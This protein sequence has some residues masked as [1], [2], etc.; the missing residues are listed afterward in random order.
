MRLILSE[1][2]RIPFLRSTAGIRWCLRILSAGATLLG[3]YF[4]LRRRWVSRQSSGCLCCL[5]IMAAVVMTLELL[6]DLYDG[7]CLAEC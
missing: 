4:G 1:H 2:G 7:T 3:S 6:Q 5:L